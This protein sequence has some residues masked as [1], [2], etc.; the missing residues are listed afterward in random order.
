MGNS[1]CSHHAVALIVLQHPSHINVFPF[2]LSLKFKYIHI[3]LLCSPPGGMHY[4]HAFLSGKKNSYH[5]QQRV[6]YLM[7]P[8]CI[9]PGGLHNRIMCISLNL[10]DR[11]KGK[12]FIWLGRKSTM[13]TTSWW[14][15]RPFPMTRHLGK[16]L[17]CFVITDVIAHGRDIC[18]CYDLL[19]GRHISL[20]LG[21]ARGASAARLRY[22]IITLLT[23]KIHYWHFVVC[24]CSA[25]HQISIYTL[26]YYFIKQICKSY[27]GR[28]GQD[29]QQRVL[30]CSSLR[31]TRRV[32]SRAIL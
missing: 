11:K 25:V 19:W 5:S 1:L 24:L 14:E 12:T 15:H 21:S 7:H 8:Q 13:I 16:K 27:W 6:T 26:L 4:M 31:L 17:Q 10:R 28:R 18:G 30:L 29:D 20:K 22:L 23:D 2:F 3:I 9:P 32:V